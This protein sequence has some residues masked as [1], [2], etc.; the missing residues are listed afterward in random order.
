MLSRQV[1]SVGSSITSSIDTVIFQRSFSIMASPV[2]CDIFGSTVAQD[3]SSLALEARIRGKPQWAAA[4]EAAD[5]LVSTVPPRSPKDG[6][7]FLRLDA[8]L[9]AMI[10]R[11]SLLEIQNCNPLTILDLGTG[12]GLFPFVCQNLGHIA[13]GLDLPGDLMRSPEREIFTQMPAVFGVTVTRF[14]I[15][16][17][18]PIE[19]IGS[20]DLITAFLVNFNNHKRSDE[21]NRGEWEYL[22]ADLQT[23]LNP[24]G[25]IALMLNS[26]VPRYGEDLQYYNENTRNFLASVG[27]VYGAAVLVRSLS[28]VGSSANSSREEADEWLRQR[29]MEALIG[30]GLR[31]LRL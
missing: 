10:S 11:T 21:W 30:G 20:Y 4:V 25:R 23:H 14:P 22:I 8:W 26:N 18:M 16:A 12:T 5:R 9:P 1:G 27:K 31:P 17:F 13:S 28:G 6:R 29:T 3:R 24:G 19:G 15:R 7:K 2:S